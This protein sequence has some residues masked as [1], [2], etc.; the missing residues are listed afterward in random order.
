M[1][2]FARISRRLLA[3]LAASVIMTSAQAQPKSSVY[4]FAVSEGTS[5]GI[6]ATQAFSKYNPLMA[7]MEKALGRKVEFVFIRGFDELEEG[8]KRGTYDLVMARP[9]DYPGRGVRD[10]KYKLVTTAKPDGQCYLIVDKSSPLKSIADARGKNVAFPEKVA[11]MSKFCAA[12]LR[13]Q[14]LTTNRITPTY[15]K[16]QGAVA[17]MVENKLVDV[18]AVASYSPQGRDWE[19]NGNRVLHKSVTQ[20]YSPL[21]AGRRIA[22]DQVNKLKA[23]LSE[24]DQSEDGRKILKTLG[25]TGFQAEGP[26]RLLKLL[27]WL[28]RK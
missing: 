26:E 14:G 15:V 9:S 24:L 5:G 3:L 12:E 18:G 25:I 11:Y 1:N 7:V 2:A 17:W 8:M 23:R 27:E 22:P 16:E 6:D 10:Y 28:E 20:P 21:I 19:K 4:L 13:D